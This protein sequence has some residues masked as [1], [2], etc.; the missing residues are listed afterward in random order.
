MYA[1]GWPP[2]PNVDAWR[3]R[4]PGLRVVQYAGNYARARPGDAAYVGSEAHADAAARTPS[5]WSF[6]ILGDEADARGVPAREYLRSVQT[7][8]DTLESA[9]VPV[10]AGGIANPRNVRYA[11]HLHSLGVAQGVNYRLARHRD[12]ERLMN[13]IPNRKWFPTLLPLR[14]NSWPLK[15]LNW[16]A[17]LRQC[18]APSFEQQARDLMASD[19]VVGVGVWCLHEGK[20]RDGHWQDWHGLIDRND[21]LTW[22]GR[23]VRRLLSE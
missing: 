17:Y 11:E 12:A 13:A 3:N 6:A 23:I 5:T 21:R 8:R 2:G 9:G 18:F 16:G 10:V 1:W 19:R 7:M 4:L 14:L 22:Q 20:L 15:Y